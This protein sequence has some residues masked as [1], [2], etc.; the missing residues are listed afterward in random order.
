MSKVRKRRGLSKRGEVGGVGI[1]KFQRLDSDEIK[2][3]RGKNP[4]V[5]WF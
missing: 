1:L 3:I 4:G 2:Q 5:F